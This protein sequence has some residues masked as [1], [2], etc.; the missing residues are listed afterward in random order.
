[1]YRKV[2]RCYP[3]DEIRSIS[4]RIDFESKADLSAY[5]E[6]AERVSGHIV[7]FPLNFLLE[8]DLTIKVFNKEYYLPA[9]NWI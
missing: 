4:D 9:E 7:P 5:P 1:M 3:D 6:L 2:F 8:E